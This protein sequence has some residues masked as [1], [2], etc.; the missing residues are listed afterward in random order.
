MGTENTLSLGLMLRVPEV[1]AFH[2]QF[3]IQ[4]FFFFFFTLIQ[5]SLLRTSARS[6]F[7]KLTG[8]ICKMNVFENFPP[9]SSGIISSLKM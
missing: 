8:N 9:D 2:T 6:F 7:F 1:K 5:T 3:Q 4:A